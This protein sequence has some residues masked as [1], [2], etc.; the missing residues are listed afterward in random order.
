MVEDF[1]RCCECSANAP[2]TEI[3][4]S[5]FL[6]SLGWRVIRK[7]T[8][9]GVYAVEWRCKSCWKKFK[10]ATAASQAPKDA[11]MRSMLPRK[12]SS[13]PGR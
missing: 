13:S 8:P 6:S 1:I 3:E 11:R 12:G 5:P 4:S 2:D 7:D 10:A 9:D